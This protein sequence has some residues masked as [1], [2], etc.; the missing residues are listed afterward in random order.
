M[1]SR[2]AP[3]GDG[4][5]PGGRVTPGIPSPPPSGLQGRGVGLL[6]AL[7]GEIDVPRG[8][9]RHGQHPRPFLAVDVGDD[10]LGVCHAVSVT[11]Y[12]SCRGGA[13]LEVA[14]VNRP[15]LDAAALALADDGVE[16][17][18]GQG[19]VEVGGASSTSKHG[20]DLL[21]V[22]ERAVGDGV[23]ADR[24]GQFPGRQRVGRDHRAG[25]LQLV[26]VLV[27]GLE[28]LWCRVRGVRRVA[29]V[30]QDRVLSHDG[31][32]LAGWL[33]WCSFTPTSRGHREF[34]RADAR[35]TTAV[36][37]GGGRGQ[38][39]IHEGNGTASNIH[40]KQD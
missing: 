38:R 24:G 5:Q 12:W 25:L 31:V 27:A 36:R 40:N 13:R 28:V 8:A 29:S 39:A 16:P 19:G 9:Q 11:R 3:P 34:D 21:G 6:H 15:D 14:A 32:S 35:K 23:V 20:H 30:D 26:P 22:H 4:G 2:R 7:L 10:G 18:Q 37:P 1:A 33:R 17:G